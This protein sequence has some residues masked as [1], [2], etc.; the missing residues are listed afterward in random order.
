MLVNVPSGVWNTFVEIVW[1]LWNSSQAAGVKQQE[2]RNKYGSVAAKIGAELLPFAVESCGGMA[3]DALRLIHT[4][5][6]EG[7]DTMRLWSSE[8]IARYSLCLT[9]TALQRGNAM[10]MLHGYTQCRRAVVASTGSDRR[11]GAVGERVQ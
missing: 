10:M 11:I 8:Q 6:E 4:I 3:Q 1:A 7:E 9:A 2:K 5:A